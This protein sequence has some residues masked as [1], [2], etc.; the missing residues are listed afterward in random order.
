MRLLE[1]RASDIILDFA[2]GKLKMVRE[3]SSNKLLLQY[4]NGETFAIS[5]EVEFYL[6]ILIE[7]CVC[8]I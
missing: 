8:E 5:E 3:S 4:L 7:Q 1:G 2:D 6:N